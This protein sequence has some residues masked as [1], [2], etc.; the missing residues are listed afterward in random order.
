MKKTIKIF[1]K[2]AYFLKR[3]VTMF[4]FMH[5]LK[6][7]CYLRAVQKVKHE[8]YALKGYYVASSANYLLMFQ[9]NLSVPFSRVK[10]PN[11]L[12]LADGTN[13]LS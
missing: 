5:H 10:Y 1:Y 6:T 7:G 2:L 9:D 13:R 4:F 11:F 8:N 12:T 3:K